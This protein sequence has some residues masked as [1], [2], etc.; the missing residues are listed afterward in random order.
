MLNKEEVERQ[1]LAAL[2]RESKVTKVE[3]KSDEDRLLERRESDLYDYIDH[4][5]S[6][7][8]RNLRELKD[9][10]RKVKDEDYTHNTGKEKVVQ[11]AMNYVQQSNWH[12]DDGADACCKYVEARTIKQYSEKKGGL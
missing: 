4:L 9:Y 8:N 12:F 2:P 10:Q 7:A 3:G 1:R 11:W 6:A 5:V